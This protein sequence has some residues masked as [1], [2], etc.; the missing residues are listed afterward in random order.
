MEEDKL[1]YDDG[2]LRRCPI[3][4]A[5]IGYWRTWKNF[6]CYRD[7]FLELMSCAGEIWEALLKLANVALFIVLF[8]IV[9][10]IKAFL[11][12]KWSVKKVKQDN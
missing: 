1:I 7:E 2:E 11:Y 3:N 4:V 10:F 9:P 12:W 5:K 6:Y 8:P